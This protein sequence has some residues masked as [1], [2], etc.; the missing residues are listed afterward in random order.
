MKNKYGFIGESLTRVREV[1]G[2]SQAELARR[3]RLTRQS[4]SQYENNANAPSFE[5][6]GALASEL[7]VPLHYFL[8]VPPAK[9]SDPVFNRVAT[10]VSKT[11]RLAAERRFE[12]L[13]E[14]VLFL[15]EFVNFPKVNFPHFDV[16][17][18]P[19][20]LTYKLIEEFATETRR[21]WGL[22][23]GMISNVAW[24]LEKNGAI[25]ARYCL[26]AE[27]YDAFSVFS[28]SD[29]TPYIVL[30]ADL[31][32]AAR[33]RFDASHELGH[34]VLHRKVEKERTTRTFD[35]A[36]IEHQAH[37]FA[38]AFLLP[39][40]SYLKE[41]AAPT[42]DSFRACKSKWRVSIQSQIYRCKDL[43]VISPEQATRLWKET[44]R[45]G[46]KYKEPLDDDLLIEQPRLLRRAMQMLLDEKVQTNK[47]I[48]SALPI[49]LDDVCELTGMPAEAFEEPR[50]SA[51]ISL[52]TRNQM[53]AS[54][55]DTDHGSGVSNIFEFRPKHN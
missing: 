29:Q 47:D 12:W 43:G 48:F 51:V 24:L 44:T 1:R 49:G 53:L 35:H 6:L 14:I 38:S 41:L 34:I 40:T 27:K 20:K 45:K 5:T 19:S 17:S 54:H 25:V 42:L 31:G 3:L 50:E 46:W 26:D 37:R 11:S 21:F 22:G 7:R 13:K 36:L 28:E 8:R 4:V 16:P 2:M 39:A 18:D 52:K 32:L 33:S 30:G 55:D 23:D 10:A 15:R 9:N